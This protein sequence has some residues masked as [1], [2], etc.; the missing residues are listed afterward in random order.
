M[1]LPLLP[2]LLVPFAAACSKESSAHTGPN[3]PVHG[4]ASIEVVASPDNPLTAAKVALGKQLFFDPRLS[5][6]G[7]TACATCHLPELAFT[8]GRATS[9]QDD[10][11]M[12]TRNAPSMLNVG[13]FERLYWDGRAAGLEANVKAACT[14]QNGARPDEIAPKLAAVE[15]YAKAFQEAFGKGPDATTIVQALASF[16]RDLRDEDS[17]YDRFAAGDAAAMSEQAQRGLALFRGRAGCV[18]CHTLPLFSDRLFHNVGIGSKAAPPDL[19]AAAQN[20][21][22]DAGKTGAFKTPSL[23]NVAKTAPY[24]HDGSVATLAEAVQLMAS[25]GIDNPHRDPL[26]KDKHLDAAELAQLVAFL[27]AL[28]GSATFTPPTLP[29]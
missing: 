24:F 14:A 1:R 18:V 7:K 11:S 8:D 3:Q 5:G 20:A 19:G 2:V 23:R 26:L 22:G 9:P 16:L 21:L 28:T 27:E 17:A 25:G 29:Q 4:L 13:Y 12:N 15:G 10:G 6:T